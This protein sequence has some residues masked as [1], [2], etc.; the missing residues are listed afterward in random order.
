MDPIL[1]LDACALR[2][3]LADGALRVVELAH[4]CLARI[5]QR[6]PEVRAWAWHDRDFVLR[7]AEALDAHR[8]AG[9]PLGPLHGLPVGIKDIIDTE[10]IPTENGTVI[11]AGRVPTADAFVVA[12]LRQAGAIVM[13]KTVTSELAFRTAGATR[14]PLNP[15]HTP[16]GSS[17]GSAA[18]VADRM[19]P[20]AI[21]TQTAGSVVRPA[22]FCGVVGYKPRRCSA[23][24][25]PMSRRGLP[26]RRACCRRRAP[27]RRSSRRSLSC[28]SR[29][30]T[31]RRWTC[32][33]RLPN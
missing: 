30:G 3:R 16:G 31:R 22:S 12:R 6:E 26:R 8:A 14:N 23:T 13:G 4:A 20:L 11:D 1:Q 18:A 33:R 32:M 24:M 5:A 29:H 27:H 19:V 7:Q 9:R 10:G 15:D 25:P 2:E 21:G 28:V 17:S